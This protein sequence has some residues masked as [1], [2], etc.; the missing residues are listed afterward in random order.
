[1]T[2]TDRSSPPRV[3]RTWHAQCLQIHGLI[4]D[5]MI[6]IPPSGVWDAPLRLSSCLVT[7]SCD[8]VPVTLGVGALEVFG[9]ACILA[10][11]AMGASA[12]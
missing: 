6:L 10:V 8:L 7:T 3:A 11:N 2:V 9:L 1:V 12:G 5:R 4:T